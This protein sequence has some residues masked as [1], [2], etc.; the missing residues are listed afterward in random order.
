M[1]KAISEDANYVVFNGAVGA[2]SGDRA[3][4]AN[5]GET[6]RLYVGNGGPNLISSFH[7]IGEIFDRVWDEGGS[8]HNRNI[9]TT[10][11][12]A[13]GAAIVDFKVDVPGTVILVDHSIFRA[14]NKGAL[15]ELRVSGPPDSAIYAGRIAEGIYLP[16]GGAV[17]QIPMPPAQPVRAA[18][19][20]E[21]IEFG[22]RVFT[23]NC[24]A[25]HQIDGRGI[26]GAFPP[27][28]RSDYLNADVRRA[29]GVVLNGLTGPITV[30]GERYASVMPAIN[31]SD[32]SVA[33][34]LTY[35]YSQWGN[36]RKVVTPDMVAGV[37]AASPP[38]AASS[39]SGH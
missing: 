28:A 18:T 3:L 24:A 35:V 15:G 39:A 19:T 32:E 12:P 14:F 22:Q 31:L 10:L 2:L 16:E 20:A 34:V 36:S 9:Q 17:Q 23:Q 5:V 29:I 11:I 37:R 27:L 4:T 8:E 1:Q 33:N 7:V 26:P 38:R 21:R 6:V 25:C 30:N 13:G